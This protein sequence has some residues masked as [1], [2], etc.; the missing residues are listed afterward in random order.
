MITA[1]HGNVERMQD[2]ATNQAHT[3]HTLSRVPVLLVGGPKETGLRDGRLADVAPTLLALLGLTK[4]GAMTGA[5][6]L[7]NGG[8]TVRRSG[9]AC[10]APA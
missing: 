10:A 8:S 6:L 1:D 9:D 3:A 5:S 4:P 7:S 2:G